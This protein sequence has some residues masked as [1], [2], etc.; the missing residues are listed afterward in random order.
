LIEIA[1]WAAMVLILGAY[2][3]LSVGKLGAQSATFHAMN[4][5]GAIGFII[6]SGWHGAIPSTVLNVI[7]LLIAGVAL[8]RITR[9]G[10]STSAM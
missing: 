4:A 1:G 2:F 9:G 5:A 10:S 3:L 7:W 6:N 8:W